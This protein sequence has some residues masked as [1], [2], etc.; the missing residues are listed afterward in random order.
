MPGLAPGRQSP[1]PLQ[2]GRDTVGA[3]TRSTTR[4]DVTPDERPRRLW[5]GSGPPSDLYRTTIAESHEEVTVVDVMR[6]D[7]P[8]PI[9]Q[10]SLIEGRIQMDADAVTRRSA[11]IKAIDTDGSLTP[12]IAADILSPLT[13]EIRIWK[14]PKYQDG[15]EELL[16]CGVFKVTKFELDSEGGELVYRLTCLDRSARAQ[17]SFG[18]PWSIQAGTPIE[19][20]IADMIR[21]KVPTLQM[22]LVT[23][24]MVTPE[25]LLPGT[26]NPWGEAVKLALLAGFTI[27]ISRDGVL[28]MVPAVTTTGLVV[29]ELK[30]DSRSITWDLGRSVDGDNAPNHIIV[31]GT[32]TSAPGVVGEAKDMDPQSPTYIGG[33]YGDVIKEYSDE[34]VNSSDQATRAAVALLGRDLG[35][36]EIVPAKSLPVSALNLDETVLVRRDRLGINTLGLVDS[37]ELPLVSGPDDHMPITVRRGVKTDT[38]IL[39]EVLV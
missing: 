9:A 5:I 4:W 28:E 26:A 25:L 10:L 34:R 24:G 17:K 27:N 39:T 13:A 12:D 18:Q 35:A 22:R 29:W 1:F 11:D 6:L 32:N 8:D 14:G 21:L 16:S 33:P 19:V 23:T 36:S 2:D 15:S 3:D 31:R 38:E 30:D 20:A 37:I 7:I